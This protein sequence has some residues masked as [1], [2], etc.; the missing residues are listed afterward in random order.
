MT[1]DFVE[2][3]KFKMYSL[4]SKKWKILKKYFIENLNKKFIFFNKI[5]KIVF[6]FFVIKFNDKFKFC[7][8]YRKFNVITKRNEYSISL[9]KKILIKIVEYKYIFKLNTLSSHWTNY[10]WISSIKNKSHSLLFQKFTNIMWCFS[11]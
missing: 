7:I 5:E 1:N 11:I 2:L 9:I 8:D 4:L 10:E 6:I 3:F